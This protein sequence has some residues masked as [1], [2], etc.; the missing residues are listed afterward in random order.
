[1]SVKEKRRANDTLLKI[2]QE[3]ESDLSNVGYSNKDPSEIA[4]LMNKDMSFSPPQFITVKV[5]KSSLL[6]TLDEVQINDITDYAISKGYI[7]DKQVEDKQVE[8]FTRRSDVLSLGFMEQGDI[9]E[10]LK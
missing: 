10:A 7:T 8:I 6:F 3:I 2:K 4:I 9:E 1:M 5:D